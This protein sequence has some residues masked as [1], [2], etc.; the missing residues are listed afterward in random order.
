MTN[1]RLVAT[2]L[3]GTLLTRE[4][5]PSR[6]AIDAVR[7]MRQSGVLVCACS[8]RNHTE[9]KDICEMAGLDDYC[10]INNGASIINWRTGAYALRRSVAP[11]QVKNIVTALLAD[12]ADYPGATLSLAGG[13][14]THVWL[15][16]TSERMLSRLD[17]DNTTG[18]CADYFYV[19]EDFNAW[20]D[21][22]KHDV[23]VIRYSLDSQLHGPR[24]KALLA[25]F[26][27]VEITTAFPGRMEIA[28]ADV[29]K[30]EC[31]IR[32]LA[33]YGV[34]RAQSL[35]IGDGPNDEDMLRVAGV[36]VAMGNAVKVLKDMAD[37]ITDT[38]ENEGF[39]KAMRRH[40]LK[41]G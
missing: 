15:G 8:G 6:A 17:E 35:A 21:A 36:S 20:I 23:Q 19:Y 31:L 28:P 32:L 22:A 24:I 14:E 40:V 33:H 2:D 12:A 41:E 27:G 5:R 3:D 9:L 25:P 4:H 37:D 29:G 16:C 38:H 11:A 7:E 10:I 39:A 34:E 18:Y 30:G 26:G 1:I 13:V